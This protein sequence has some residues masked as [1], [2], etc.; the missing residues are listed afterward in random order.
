MAT[1]TPIVG[2]RL[3]VEG[4]NIKDQKDALIAQSAEDLALQTI[5]VLENPE[6]GQKLAKNAYKLVR[7]EYNWKKI[8]DRLDRVYQDVGGG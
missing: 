1:K 4:I 8:S 6:L 5:K 7:E 2:T 3:A